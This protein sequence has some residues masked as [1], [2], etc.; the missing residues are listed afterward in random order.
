M[1]NIGKAKIG[2]SQ[3]LFGSIFDLFQ[4]FHRHFII[5]SRLLFVCRFLISI[6]PCSANSRCCYV[7]NRLACLCACVQ[8]SVLRT[9]KCVCDRTSTCV[10]ESVELRPW[11]FST[12]SAMKG[13]QNPPPFPFEL[14][15]RRF[16]LQ[17]ERPTEGFLYSI[18]ILTQVGTLKL[19]RLNFTQSSELII[20]A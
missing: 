14:E 20:A 7:R 16:S 8:V 5:L 3:S 9:V 2:N 10:C 15:T 6:L 4:D 12:C 19:A 11:Q 1:I 13:D 17:K 18:I